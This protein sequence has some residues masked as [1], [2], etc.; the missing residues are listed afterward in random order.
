M[1]VG[2]SFLLFYLFIF[3]WAEVCFFT[4]S[5]QADHYSCDPV[6]L[7]YKLCF[8][9]QLCTARLF[10]DENGDDMETFQFLYEHVTRDTEFENW[11]SEQLCDHVMGNITGLSL[12]QQDFIDYN[13]LDEFYK[14]WIRF[15]SE[16]REC[17][18]TNQYFDGVIKSCIC[19]QDKECT[20]IHP[21]DIEFHTSHYQLLCWLIIFLIT[22]ISVYFIKK[23]QSLTLL[24]EEIKMLLT[25]KV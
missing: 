19:K 4:E 25:N 18:H 2:F 3:F 13:T 20:Y 11:I 14:L 5:I 24:F 10:I 8:S 17:D 9:N 23:A 6:L 16:H 12:S 15:M 7:S 1:K 21:H 22:A